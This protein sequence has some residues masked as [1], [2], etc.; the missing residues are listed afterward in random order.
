MNQRNEFSMSKNVQKLKHDE[1]KDFQAL[2]E[3][4]IQGH[5]RDN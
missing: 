2:P 3:L 5:S 4:I 1:F